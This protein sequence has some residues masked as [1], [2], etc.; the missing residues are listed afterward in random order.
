MPT[1]ST[2]KEPVSNTDPSV[3]ILLADDHK[4]IRSGLRELI[5][6]EDRFK[7]VAEAG[8]GR[9]AVEKC[10]ELVPDVVLMDISMPDLNGIDATRRLIGDMPETKIIILSVH[11]GRRI[12]AETFKAGASGYLLK[13]CSS[14]EM[15]AAINAVLAGETYLSPKIASIVREDYLRFLKRDEPSKSS[16]LSPREREVLQLLA[17][18]LNTKEIAFSLD[19]SV[20]T[21]EVHRLNIMNKLNLHSIAE[22]TKYAIREKITS[23]EY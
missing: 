7:V 22:L 12:V 21:V 13:N 23:E 19:L 1:R 15:L 16:N 9:S 5:E 20:K 18:G 17:E 11:S 4:I 3:K 10:L 2:P 6:K 14:D 8:T